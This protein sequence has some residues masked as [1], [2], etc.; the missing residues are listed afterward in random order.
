M[1]GH[2]QPYGAVQLFIPSNNT[3]EQCLLPSYRVLVIYTA[4]E[5]ETANAHDR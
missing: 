5:S 4:L 1:E 3:G 2:R